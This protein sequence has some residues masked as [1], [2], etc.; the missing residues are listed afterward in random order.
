MPTTP[1][2]LRNDQ[3]KPTRPEDAEWG[4]IN[5]VLSDREGTGILQALGLLVTSLQHSS[6]MKDYMIGKNHPPVKAA[7]QF[8]RT[9]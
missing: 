1:G 4:C 2:Y 8:A 6:E 7:E 9:F 5:G 3:T